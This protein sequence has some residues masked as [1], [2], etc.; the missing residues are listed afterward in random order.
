MIKPLVICFHSVILF[1][2]SFFFGDGPNTVTG[3]FPKSAKAGS[4][5]PAE[6]VVKKGAIGGFAKLQIEVPQGLTIKEV[7]SK[8]ATFSFDSGL[9]KYIWTSA[10]QE[11]EFTIKIMVSVSPSASGAKT[12]ASK[13]SYVNNNAKEVVEMAPAEVMIGDG[14]DV[15]AATPDN[16]TST[17][18]STP[19]TTTPAATETIAATPPPADNTTAPVTT[20]PPPTSNGEPSSNVTCERTVTAG[21]AAGE[22]NVE[23]KIKKPGI[24]GFAKYQDLVP[25][26]YKVKT[27]LQ[28]AGS[29][30]SEADGK[31][32]FVWVSL[33][34]EDEM[35]VGYV[36]EKTGT[37]GAVT[38]TGEFSYLEDNQT[39]KIKLPASVINDNGAV[40]ASNPPVNTEPVKTE[41]PPN[42]EPV[43]TEPAA[44]QQVAVEN[45]QPVTTE[46][47]A[48]IAKKEGNVSY[49]VQI[50][51]FRN[52][53]A[54]DVLA[55]KFNISETVKSEMAEGYSKF[56]VGNF[57]EYKG[58][59]DHR[60]G[61]KQK[62]CASAFVAAYNG[63]KRITVQEAL[64]ITNQKWFK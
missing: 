64:M 52:A 35:T 48:P 29:S 42:T 63:P 1:I 34:A 40:A 50:G 30:M 44:T 10:P 31:V 43:K 39:K 8:G 26:G 24:K 25:A 45:T 2:F 7:D 13:Y 18:S 19:A 38:I 3:N 17:E 4:E 20:T 33:P 28:T 14:A 21:S 15:A 6:I 46:S 41:T 57:N 11:P 59:R 32:K 9:A 37:P 58:A 27:H 54:S 56:M 23:I 16:T 5:F 53:I 51:A 55:K 22:Y 12:I 60:E 47:S 49:C 36:L 61:V 62:G